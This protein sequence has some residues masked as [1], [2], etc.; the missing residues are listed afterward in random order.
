VETG[1]AVQVEQGA[2]ERLQVPRKDIQVVVVIAMPISSLPMLET[3]RDQDVG[4]S[5]ELFYRGACNS[6]EW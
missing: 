2:R 5:I 4:M 1:E 3:W 6:L